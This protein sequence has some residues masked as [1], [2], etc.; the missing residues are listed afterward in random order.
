MISDDN[1]DLRH[2]AL[3]ALVLRYRDRLPLRALRRVVESESAF[4][5]DEA[6]LVAALEFLR[7]LGHV[8]VEIDPLGS[9]RYWQATAQGVLHWE[10]EKGL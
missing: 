9:T 2:L 4:S 3:E 6:Q 1:E 10:R 8:R 7:D 5:F